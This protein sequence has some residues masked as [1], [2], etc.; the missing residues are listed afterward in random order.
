MLRTL[1]QRKR[2]AYYERQLGRTLQV[3]FESGNGSDVS[4]FSENYVRVS[5]P[6]QPGLENRILPVR[7]DSLGKDAVVGTV[8]ESQMELG[9]YVSLPV[10][11]AVRG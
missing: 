6:W 3:L 7:C 2:R 9:A 5:V 11:S 4:G 1:S 10:V 8:A